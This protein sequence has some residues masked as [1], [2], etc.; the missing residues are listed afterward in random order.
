MEI[1]N[2]ECIIQSKKKNSVGI[3]FVSVVG[4]FKGVLQ[5]EIST[6]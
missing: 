4:E 3:L 1:V 6:L 2:F 5:K